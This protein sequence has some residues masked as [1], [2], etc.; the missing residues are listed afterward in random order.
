LPAQTLNKDILGDVEKGGKQIVSNAIRRSTFKEEVHLTIPVRVPALVP[1]LARERESDPT[2]GLAWV[3]VQVG[4]QGLAQAAVEAQGR[5][6]AWGRAGEDH[7]GPA[8][9]RVRV[10]APEWGKARAPD[11]VPD[12]V[13]VPVQGRALEWARVQAEAQASE[14]V[15]AQVP[16]VESAPVRARAPGLASVLARVRASAPG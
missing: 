7:P 8:L 13:E 3:R 6:P 16:A 2:P 1:V 12:R 9:E 4:A 10:R 11:Q 15:R 5:V 14:S